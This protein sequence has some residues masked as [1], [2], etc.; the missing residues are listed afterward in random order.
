M[1][2]V[3]SILG[4]PVPCPPFLA[5]HCQRSLPDQTPQK[6]RG[7][8]GTNLA[9]FGCVSARDAPMSIYVLQ[10][11]MLLLQRVKT[12][13]TN[14]LGFEPKAPICT[15]RKDVG[16]SLSPSSRFHE[17][18]LDKPPEVATGFSRRALD[19]FCSFSAGCLPL[20]PQM[21]E[22]KQLLEV[23]GTVL[24][25]L[26]H[27]Q[28]DKVKVGLAAGKNE[29]DSRFVASVIRRSR[30]PPSK[31]FAENGV[32]PASCALDDAGSLESVGEAWIPGARVC[33]EQVVEPDSFR[34]AT[35]TRNLY[36]IIVPLH[37]H[38]SKARV[39]AVNERVCDALSVGPF[40]IVRNADPYHPNEELLF[41]VG[42]PEATLQL[43]HRSQ[44]WP[45]KEVV[46]RNDALP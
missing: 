24:A 30:A 8:R 19:N 13:P 11:Q 34:K 40:R 17:S 29:R 21:I 35:G 18:R 9:E 46:D 37:M 20:Q 28:S 25:A 36:T 1:E 14:I 33:H 42:R 22:Q 12:A 27:Y 16:L 26:F 7:L 43:V 6:A 5:V 10:H 3:R 32:D 15:G 39:V 38:R 41:L 2:G 45:A 23:Q 31:L 4:G 44:Q